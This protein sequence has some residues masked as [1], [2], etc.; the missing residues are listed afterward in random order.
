MKEKFA[1]WNI[2]FIQY[3]KRDWKKIIIWV[4]GLGLFASAFVPAME[5][6]TK[7]EG[8]LGMYETLQNPAMISMVGRT[9]VET[10]S[11]YTLGAMYSH[12][13][14]LFSGLFAMTISILHVIG[15]TR[16]EEDLGL[17]ELIRSFQVGRQSNSLAVIVE[18]I[19]INILLIF[20]ISGIM[21]SFGNDTISAEGALLFG[22]SIGIAGIMGAGIALIM[23]QI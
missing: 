4:L 19:L 22:T 5:E 11:D 17:T 18:T 21:M 10:A 8:L 2:L 14:L 9:P 1:R 13:M 12:M 23:A 6:I 16:K 3:L 7:G 15:H 20:F